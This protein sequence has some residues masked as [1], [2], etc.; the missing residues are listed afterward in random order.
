M[1]PTGQPAKTGSRFTMLSMSRMLIG[2]L[3]MLALTLPVIYGYSFVFGLKSS[4]NIAG[5]RMIGLFVTIPPAMVIGLVVGDWVWCFLGTRF[6]G[7][8]RQEVEAMVTPVLPIPWLVRYK[9][10]YMSVLFGPKAS[11]AGRQAG[12]PG[13]PVL[14]GGPDGPDSVQNAIY[15]CSAAAITKN[16]DKLQRRPL[17]W[18]C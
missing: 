12:T 11:P 8:T 13:Q 6:L 3:C 10:W 1:G 2:S 17:R 4:S 18:R 5:P 16:W 7:F 14:D 15:E 9:N